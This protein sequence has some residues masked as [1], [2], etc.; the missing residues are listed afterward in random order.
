MQ[1]IYIYGLHLIKDVSHRWNFEAAL[2]A[3]ACAHLIFDSN[4]GRL[5]SSDLLPHKKQRDHRFPIDRRVARLRFSAAYIVPRAPAF[6]RAG[7]RIRKDGLQA[8]YR[9]ERIDQKG[10]SPVC[11]RWFRVAPFPR[12][13]SILK[14]ATHRRLTIRASER[15]KQDIT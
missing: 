9:R 7:P 4:L 12:R 15:D 5:T 2:A 1:S 10:I 11:C 14:L 6:V 3:A 8:P 13:V